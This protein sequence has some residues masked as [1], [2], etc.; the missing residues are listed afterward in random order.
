MVWRICPSDDLT[1]FPILEDAVLRTYHEKAVT[2]VPFFVAIREET[3]W[4]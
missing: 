4:R 2:L 1:F 3:E